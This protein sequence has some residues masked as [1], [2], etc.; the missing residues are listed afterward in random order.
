MLTETAA[1][2]LMREVLGDRW[3]IARIRDNLSE[4]EWFVQLA[5]VVDHFDGQYIYT[6]HKSLPIAMLLATLEAKLFELENEA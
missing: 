1:F 2:A 3:R 4:Q 6:T 5:G